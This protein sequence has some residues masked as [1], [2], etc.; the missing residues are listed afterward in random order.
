M[1]LSSYYIKGHNQSQADSE[2]AA[3]AVA[4]AAARAS[5]KN[6]EDGGKSDFHCGHGVRTRFFRVRV[7][8]R[9]SPGHPADGWGRV[10]ACSVCLFIIV[11]DYVYVGCLACFDAET[12]DDLRIRLLC[13]ALCFCV[14]ACLLLLPTCLDR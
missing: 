10:S 2:A 7:R 12:L 13:D 5:R 9:P 4:T 8:Q 14:R 11:F 6:K 3:A 1:G